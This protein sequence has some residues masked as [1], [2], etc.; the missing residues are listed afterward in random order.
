[1]GDPV[2]GTPAICVVYGQ[3][4]TASNHRQLNPAS[5]QGY[6]ALHAG[7]R[8]HDKC[9]HGVLRRP[10]AAALVSAAV[11]AAQAPRITRQGQ[12]Q[13]QAVQA[14]ASKGLQA[15]DCSRAAGG[16]GA[17]QRCTAAGCARSSWPAC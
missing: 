10:A 7:T 5:Y 12:Q 6:V 8:I 13:V 14:K 4:V 11:K 17:D 1:M 9:L 3:A 16:G 15:P 2:S